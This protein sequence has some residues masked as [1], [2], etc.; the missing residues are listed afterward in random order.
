[1]L[2]LTNAISFNA[3]WKLSFDSRAT[4]AGSF[5]LLDGSTRQAQLMRLEKPLRYGSGDGYQAVELPYDA[6]GLSML[7][8][9][10]DAGRFA[11]VEAGLSRPFVAGVVAG[12]QEQTGGLVLPKFE[13]QYSVGAKEI[14]TSLGMG[15]AFSDQADLSG[16]NG[17]GG[18]KIADVVHQAWVQVNEAGTVAAA[19]T[20]VI[21]G[22][23]A[24]PDVLV[25]DRPFL[26]LIRDEATGA[27][28]FLGRLV[29]PA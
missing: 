15:E 3:A 13:L 24:I 1:V 19:A 29:D 16:I 20:G 28:L 11:E 22:P 25:V 21:I 12:L 4:R 26:F 5:H 2:V 14:L 18:L 27:I 23:T 10:P 17:V 7:V 6:A 9:V 8:I